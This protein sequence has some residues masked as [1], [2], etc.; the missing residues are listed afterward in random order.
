LLQ[1]EEKLN[2]RIYSQKYLFFLAN[3]LSRKKITLYNF[4]LLSGINILIYLKNI[5]P[6]KLF[7][8]EMLREFQKAQKFS[9]NK[10]VVYFTHIRPLYSSEIGTNFNSELGILVKEFFM[11]NEGLLSLIEAEL[12]KKD[13][14]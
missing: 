9:F 6:V 5:N 4:A 2:S 11:E 13:R 7:F 1:N 12:F 14:Y 8:T 3:H 10:K